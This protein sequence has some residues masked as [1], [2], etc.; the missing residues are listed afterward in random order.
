MKVVFCGDR[1]VS[2]AMARF[3]RGEGD[4]IVGLGLN[5]A[6]HATHAEQLLAAAA[7]DPGMVFYA[8]SLSSPAALRRLSRK[9][10]DLGVCCGY[11][12]I[13]KPQL[14]ELPRWGWVNLH[15]SYLPYNRGLDPLQWAMVEG[16]PAGVTLHRMTEGIDAG[17]I[18]A[19]VE[20]PVHP[21][22]TGHTLGAR[23]DAAALG[24]LRDAWPRLRRG[25]VEGVAQDDD[26]AT[27][28]TVADCDRLRRLDLDATMPVRRV[29]DIL[30]GYSGDGW[31]A[32]YYEAGGVRLSVHTQVHLGHAARRGEVGGA[33]R[34]TPAGSGEAAGN[35]S[36]PFPTRAGGQE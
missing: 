30:R 25:E 8:R 3:I 9:S 20:V 11:A 21:T 19:Q 35:G 18:I 31:S 32:V 24:L 4:E 27:Y 13:L 15:R 17:P 1:E 2:V 26:L 6:P 10:P 12:S 28:H 34:S 22:D 33:P 5:L 16:T 7:V 29:L 36:T 14:L 23:A